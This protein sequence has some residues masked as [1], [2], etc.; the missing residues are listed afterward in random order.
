MAKKLALRT[1]ALGELTTDALQAVV[2]GEQQ[3]PS[4]DNYCLTGP[5][6]TI[7]LRWCLST[8]TTG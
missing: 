4:L 3:V 2:A 8:Y 1:E 5:Y 6:P 7:P